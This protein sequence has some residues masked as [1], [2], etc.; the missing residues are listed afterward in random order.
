MRRPLCVFC[1][2]MLGVA[3]VCAFLPQTELFVPFAAFFVAVCLV[4]CIFDAARK[5]ALC[6]LLGAAVGMASVLYT[7]NRLERIRVQYAARPLVLTAEVESVSDSYYPGVVDAVLRVE[8]INGAK[9]SF[10][11]ECETLPECETGQRVQGRFVLSVPAQQSR[12]GLYSDGIVL[13]AEPDEEKPDFKQLGQSSSFRA[14]TH[15]LQQRLS[16]ALRRRMDG[17]TGGVLAAMT[18]GDRTHLSPV[19]R[20][21]YRGAGLAHVLVVSGMHV[22]I[23]CGE[24]FRLDARRKKERCYAV[25]R[26]RAVWK[27]LLALLLVGVTGFTP[28]VLRAAAAVWVSALGV[29]LYAPP[30]TLTSLAV[31]GIA[32][33]AGSSYAVCDIGFEL[34]FAAVLGTVAGGACIRRTQDAWYRQFWKNA[35]NPVKRPWYFKLPE[36]LWGLAESVCISVCASAA[37]FP[38]LVLRGLSV[39]IWAVVSSVAVL[40]L[41]QPM[42]L[43]GLGTA[44]TGLMPALAPL[45]GALSVLSAALTG[46]LDRWAVWIAAKPGAGIYFDTAYATIVCLVLI[47][48]C[49]LAFRWRLRLRVAVPGLLLTAALAIGAGNALCRDVVHVDLVG[50]ANSPA[51]VVSQNHTAVVLFRG[52]ASTQRAVENQL[53]RRGVTTVELLADLRLDPENAC[54]LPARTMCRVAV[55]PVGSAVTRQTQTAAVETLRTRS[56]CLVRLTIGEQQFVTVSGTV[57]LAEP[58]RVQWLLASPAKPEAVQWEQLLSRSDHYQWM[59][60]GEAV[61]ASLSLRPSGGWRAE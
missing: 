57:T 1:A 26:L 16:A 48:L 36:R 14:R 61:Y 27:A 13:L 34:S 51:V 41:I 2:G 3:L 39:S 22:S 25:L 4:L 58:V 17:K 50:S 38:V 29:W 32:M 11:V 37:T 42:M 24:V 28:S 44:F 59:Q 53:A 19:L 6:I 21:A 43:L 40:W 20:S 30:D 35:K 15:R 10:R 31:A 8:K 9:T 46:L 52:G 12:V 18:V 56:G 60:G 55:Q 49:W 23:L 45:H 33:T 54:T 7:A 5:A 47:V